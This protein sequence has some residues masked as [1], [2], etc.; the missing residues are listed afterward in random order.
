M[1][2]PVKALWQSYLRTKART[3]KA[4]VETME[5][6]NTLHADAD[7]NIGYF[8]GNLLPRRD[9]KFDWTKP[10]DGTNPATEWGPLYA[11]NQ[12]PS[13]YNLS[14]GW[15]YNANNS[16]WSAAGSARR[17]LQDFPAY[18]ERGTE[19]ARGLHA[20]RVLNGVNNL[21]VDSLLAGA[22]DSY[23]PWLAKPLPVLLRA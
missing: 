20:L 15:L 16:P 4:Y 3:Y 1:D 23:L 12:L 8:H 19:S 10:V 6:K 9:T 7:E 2:E 5:I 21:T 17:K 22:Y 13:L 11:S 14:S 18:V